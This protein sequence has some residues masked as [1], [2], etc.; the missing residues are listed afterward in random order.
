VP[1]DGP[2]VPDFDAENV[3]VAAR[4]AQTASGKVRFGEGR[5]KPFLGFQGDPKR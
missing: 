2:D 4:V 5:V 1:T 3:V